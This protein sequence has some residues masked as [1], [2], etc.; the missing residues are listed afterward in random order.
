MKSTIKVVLVCLVGVACSIDSQF[1]LA[2]PPITSD[3][4]LRP[5]DEHAVIKQFVENSK[6]IKRHWVNYT[7]SGYVLTLLLTFS[8]KQADDQVL[9]GYEIQARRIRQILESEHVPIQNII[10]RSAEGILVASG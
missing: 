3:T 9:R 10:L 4:A 6:G 5:Q 8:I 7:P 2:D 1:V